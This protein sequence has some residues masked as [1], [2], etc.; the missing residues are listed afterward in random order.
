MAGTIDVSG[1]KPYEVLESIQRTS[2]SPFFGVKMETPYYQY[3]EPIQEEQEEKKMEVKEEIKS[4]PSKQEPLEDD[5]CDKTLIAN[6]FEFLVKEGASKKEKNDF[7]QEYIDQCGKPKKRVTWYSC[8][9]RQNCGKDTISDEKRKEYAASAK[10][11]CPVSF[12]KKEPTTT[13]TKIKEKKPMTPLNCYKRYC[14]SGKEKGGWGKT[15]TEC[16]EEGFKKKEY[17]DKMDEWKKKANE[18]CILNG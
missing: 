11:G 5:P 14:L 3:V 7:L 6:K 15:L 9:T 12:T 2:K 1:K 17:V 10:E 16:N 4:E 13:T 18:G 8:C